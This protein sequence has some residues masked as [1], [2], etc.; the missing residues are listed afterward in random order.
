[1]WLQSLE[2]SVRRV[3]LRGLVKLLAGDPP[4]PLPD[5]RARPYRVLFIRDDG[6]GDL[7]V[8]IEAMRAIAESSPT[9]TLDVLAS[10]QNAP[11]ARTLPFVGEVLVHRR[12]FLPRSLPMWRRLRRRR[13]DAVVD[14]RVVVRNVNMHTTALL[15]STR[16]PWRIGLGGRGND[17]VYTTRIEPR[18]LPHW[19]DQVVALA[20]PF[21]VSPDS[22]DWRA[23]LTVAPERRAEAER[24]WE[25]QGGGRPRVMLN[26]SVGHRERW[27]PP[28]SYAQVL[29][30]VRARMPAST[31]IVVS[32]PADVDLA[33]RLASEAR[34]RS[35]L[36]SLDQA[37][38]MVA[39]SDL[40]ISP[41]TALTHVAS[42][43][44]VP[45]LALQ[46][47]GT[48]RFVPYRTPGRAVFSRDP[49]RL[50]EMPAARVIEALD[51]LIAELGPNRGWISASPHSASRP[52]D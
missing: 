30:R 14:G 1:M 13:Y 4:P 33:R 29:A 28:E 26:V 25:S 50:S 48:E 46:R 18:D 11:L 22:R 12:R 36:F 39:A 52:D 37:V 51:A 2:S 7:I 42:A 19:T 45:T 34:A 38:A 35:A 47:V 5:W 44:S 6:I 43:F 17:H 23:R 24:A 41:D 27:W 31:I 49:R 9:L 20:E 21:G 8:S 40:L 10:P 15:L 16:A 3:V 32:M